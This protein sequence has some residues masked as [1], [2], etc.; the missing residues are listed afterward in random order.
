MLFA[1]KTAAVG[2]VDVRIICPLRSD[3]PLTDWAS[4]SYLRELHE[5]GAQIYLYRSGFMHSKMMVSDDTL[6]TCGSTNLDSRS[7]E[8]NF[9][10]NAFV[11]DEGI[12]LRMKKVFLDD[13]SQSV[14]LS[15]LPRRLNPHF[16]PRLWES[17]TRLLSPLL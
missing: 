12:A 14:L 8:N 17:L 13:Q 5:A 7:F 9:E 15:D 11:Y 3:A 4:R 10:V 2:G 6:S 1:L 16:L